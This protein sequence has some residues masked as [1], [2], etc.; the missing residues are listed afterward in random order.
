MHRTAIIIAALLVVGLT[1]AAA[2]A[3][4]SSSSDNRKTEESKG[5][6]VD[7]L[8]RGLKSAAKN[9]EKEIPKIGSAI[10]NA[11]KKITGKGPE[12]PSSQ[13]S[14]KENK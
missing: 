10:G 1:Q 5:I 6:T 12:N 4:A 2:A 13:E 14:V 7:D 9:I 11:V 3:D 8:G